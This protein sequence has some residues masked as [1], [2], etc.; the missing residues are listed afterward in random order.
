MPLVPYEIIQVIEERLTNFYEVINK[1]QQKRI[2]ELETENKELKEQ[3]HNQSGSTGLVAKPSKEEVMKMLFD[4]FGEQNFQDGQFVG[5][6]GSALTNLKE[7]LLADEVDL[8]KSLQQ[9]KD[10]WVLPNKK[11]LTAELLNDLLSLTGS[12]EDEFTDNLLDM[13][14]FELPKEVADADKGGNL[15]LPY[16]YEKNNFDIN[17]PSFCEFNP[18]TK[19][20]NNTKGH[21]AIGTGVGKTTKTV[22]CL[23]QGG[24]NNIILVC[25]TPALTQ[26]AYD[27]HNS[28]LQEWSC[29][30]HNEKHGNYPVALNDLTE[31]NGVSVM[32]DSY[33][34]GFLARNLLEIKKIKCDNPKAKPEIEKELKNVKKKLISKDSIIV[35]DEAHFGSST[36]QELIRQAI[37]LGYKVIKMSATF[38]GI[39]FSTTSACPIVSMHVNS[40]TPVLNQRFAESKTLLFLKN[41]NLSPS[42]RKLLEEINYVVFDKTNASAST[43]I[44]YGLPKGSLIICDNTYEMGFTFL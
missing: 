41:T 44:S 21:L 38:K 37:Y 15:L 43:G 23:C 40:F 42:Q 4:I 13:G 39:P 19:E 26:D 20:I 10:A 14:A 25:P 8:A 28:W 6:V 35:F 31:S 34:L 27:H 9:L 36:Y 18:E 12:Y 30:V 11:P 32:Q 17:N 1:E 3:L 16:F 5:A 22:A 33:L 29:V 24:T 7:Y 2:V